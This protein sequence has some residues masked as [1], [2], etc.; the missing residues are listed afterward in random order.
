MIEP[1]IDTTTICKSPY[2]KPRFVRGLTL[3]TKL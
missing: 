2:R 1:I 3:D